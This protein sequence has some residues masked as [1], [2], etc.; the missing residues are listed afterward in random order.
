MDESLVDDYGHKLNIDDVDKMRL[1]FG[2]LYHFLARAF[3][4]QGFG[5]KGKTLLKKSLKDYAARKHSILK[6]DL[7]N[8]PNSSQ[9]LAGIVEELSNV[10]QIRTSPGSG[11]VIRISESPVFKAWED[12][13][14][15]SEEKSIADYYLSEV[16]GY[17]L[18]HELEGV[19][20]VASGSFSSSNRG[21]G[22]ITL[23]YQ[24]S[25]E[26]LAGLTSPQ[27]PEDEVPALF[28]RCSDYWAYLY[29][30]LAK[31]LIS[32]GQ[33]GE[34]SLREAIREFGVHRGKILRREVLASGQETTIKSL[35]ENYDLPEDPRFEQD[36]IRQDEEVRVSKETRCNFSE[37]W[38]ELEDGWRIGRIYCEEVHHAFYS[39]FEPAI[40]VNITQTLTR[41]DDYCD[42]VLFL[43]KANKFRIEKGW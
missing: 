27:T 28:K 7:E 43:R 29:Y 9:L 24:G 31:N 15:K 25:D 22:E 16:T 38:G 12:L 19:E 2:K 1:T 4:D 37:V 26:A 35:F 11:E 17:L 34:A 20:E 32:L 5:K 36:L 10:F 33:A 21:A 40:Q 13:G 39:A 30:F 41:G 6:E 42:F 23:S 8:D 14:L 3:F 18:Q